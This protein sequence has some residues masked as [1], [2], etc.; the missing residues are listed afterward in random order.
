MSLLVTRKFSFQTGACPDGALAVIR[1]TGRVALSASYEFEIILA[2]AAPEVEPAELLRHPARLVIHR[3][4]G[5]DVAYPGIVVRAALE[6]EVDGISIYRLHLAPRLAWLDLSRHNQVFLN[7]SVPDF[8]AA[9]LRDGG[10]TAADYDFRLQGDYEPVEY[11]CQYGESHLQFVQRWAEREGIGYFFDTSGD[12]E[13]VVFTD[14]RLAHVPPPQGD[15]LTYA[16]PSGLEASHLDEA[17]QRFVHRRNQLPAQVHL[18]DYNYR[19]P[20]LELAATA[21]VDSRGR[22]VRY[23]YGEH[24]RTPA[25]GQRLARIRAD[26]LLCCRDL[27][28]GESTV[29][30]MSPGFTFTLERHYR[31]SLNGRYLTIGMEIEGNQAGCLTTGLRQALSER[32]GA[33]S[34]RNR[35]TAIPADVQFRPECRTPRPVIHGTLP[36]RVDAAGSGRYAELDNQGRYTVVMPFD[37]SGRGGGKASCRLRL[38]QPYGGPREGMHCPLHK[39]AEVVVGFVAGDPDRPVLLGAIP[40]A[41]SPSPVTAA[42]ATRSI[43]RTGSGN[44]VQLEDLKDK[45][46]IVLHVPS[47]GVWMRLGAPNDPSWDNFKETLKKWGEDPKFIYD[48]LPELK[49]K[50]LTVEAGVSLTIHAGSENQVVAGENLLVVIIA[51]EKINLIE[52]LEFFAGWRQ[53]LYFGLRSEFGFHRLDFVGLHTKLSAEETKLKGL[54]T[55]TALNRTG[56]QRVEERIAGVDAKVQGADQQIRNVTEATNATD[57]QMGGVRDEMAQKMQAIET[58]RTQVHTLSQE[59]DQLSAEAAGIR[60]AVAATIVEARD[61]NAATAGLHTQMSDVET[62][63]MQLAMVTGPVVMDGD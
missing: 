3:E 35:F 13:R 27:F 14:T 61:L 32:E 5:G 26:S 15:T 20:G 4:A 10:L 18:R 56:L 33:A 51:E 17:V 50:G 62:A 63:A 45:A 34:F 22:G 23:F 54:G 60:D 8:L 46:H 57:V 37:E 52:W 44:K 6:R 21:P 16:P 42:N 38:A 48:L 36:A 55:T 40:N 19:A 47:Q 58:M 31:D 11:V 2:G 29:P 43:L 49:E 24:F 7:Q 39:G 25:D 28:L 12:A 30:Y 41:E 59:A 53:F 1:F 9:V